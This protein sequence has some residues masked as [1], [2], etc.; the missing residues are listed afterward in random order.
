MDDPAAIPM[1]VEYGAEMGKMIL[2]DRIDRGNDQT[3]KGTPGDQIAHRSDCQITA[4]S[5]S[6]ASAAAQ[7]QTPIA[8]RVVS[9]DEHGVAKRVE[10]IA[11]QYGCLICSKDPFTARK[12]TNQHATAWISAGGSW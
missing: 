6:D 1:L 8:Q 3:C 7:A 4:C 2:A 9:Q 11:F 5:R 10:P 12:G